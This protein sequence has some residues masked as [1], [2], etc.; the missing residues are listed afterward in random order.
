MMFNQH[1]RKRSK[2]EVC[3]ETDVVVAHCGSYAYLTDPWAD[4]TIGK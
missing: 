4:V 1:Y 3:G 2:C